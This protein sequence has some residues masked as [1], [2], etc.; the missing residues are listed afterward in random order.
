MHVM[1]YHHS[2][3]NIVRACQHVPGTHN[4]HQIPLACQK[5]WPSACARRET[6][7]ESHQTQVPLSSV[8]RPLPVQTALPA[9]R[10][11]KQGQQLRRPDPAPMQQRS[12]SDVQ[13]PDAAGGSGVAVQVAAP[14]APPLQVPPQV[15]QVEAAAQDGERRRGH[16]D[17]PQRRAAGA[18]YQRG[19]SVQR[20]RR[21]GCESMALRCAAGEKSCKSAGA[22]Q[23][24]TRAGHSRVAA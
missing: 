22:G 2:R 10:A 7:A 20:R 23:G 17:L 4:P 13:V 6:A 16:D 15:A 3:R 5:S 11:C 8:Q 21:G 12:C 1:T 14:L 18:T 19:A 9:P 24:S